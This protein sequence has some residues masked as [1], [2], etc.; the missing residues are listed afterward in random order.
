MEKINKIFKFRFV[1]DGY[2]VRYKKRMY[3]RLIEYR[4][5]SAGDKWE[6]EEKYRLAT[7]IDL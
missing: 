6:E 7:N 1:G 4:I 5:R 3:K 2:T